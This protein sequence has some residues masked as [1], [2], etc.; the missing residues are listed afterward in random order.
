V[1]LLLRKYILCAYFL[2]I[3]LVFFYDD[4]IYMVVVNGYGITLVS[5]FIAPLYVECL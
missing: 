3:F 5:F 2:Y 1:A 4:R